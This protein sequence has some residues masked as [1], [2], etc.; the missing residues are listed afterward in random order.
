MKK[1]EERIAKEGKKTRLKLQKKKSEE[2][3]E[4]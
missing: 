1:K 2:F 3:K 4:V